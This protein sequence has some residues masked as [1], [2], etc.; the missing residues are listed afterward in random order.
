MFETLNAPTIQTMLRD[1]QLVFVVDEGY[2][3][4]DAVG[5]SDL[6]RGLVASLLK[7]STNRR[8]GFNDCV[9]LLLSMCDRLDGHTNDH[10]TLSQS[11]HPRCV[12]FWEW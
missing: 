8:R 7:V 12:L 10:S 5:L 9:T 1:A 3:S 2:I 4:L 11:H 6:V